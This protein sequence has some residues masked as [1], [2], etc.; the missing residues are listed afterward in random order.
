M[1]ELQSKLDQI[2]WIRWSPDGRSFLANAQTD[3]GFGIHRVNIQ[4]GDFSP[5]VQ[6]RIG[7]PAAWSRDAKAIYYFRESSVPKAMQLVVRDLETGEEKEL[8]RL[9]TP[10]YYSGGVA[11]SRDG[12]QLA[13]VM[14]DVE[15]QSIVLKAMPAAGGEAREL[16]R[17]KQSEGGSAG[18]IV[19]SPD[20]L[21][22]LF[23]RDNNL[24]RVSAKGG[25]P[26]KL[27]PMIEGMRDLHFHPNGRRMAFVAGQDK[28]EVWVM[29]NF[30]PKDEKP[31][32]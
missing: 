4:T 30:L 11:L 9:A 12:R 14:T 23:I 2:S 6:T 21:H 28:S 31:Q 19:W 22:V 1:R 16:L 8:H 24:W 18:G 10:S 29:E 26:Q 25:E 17:V 3:E 15:N 27:G 13:F 32:K 5:V 20:G 7:W